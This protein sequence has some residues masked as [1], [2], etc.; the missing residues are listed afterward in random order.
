VALDQ[1]HIVR[2][3]AKNAHVLQEDAKLMED[4]AIRVHAF[5]VDVTHEQAA[6]LKANLLRLEKVLNSLECE[7]SRWSEPPAMSAMGR[8][9]HCAK[10]AMGGKQT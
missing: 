6:R 4:G 2:L 9:R 1:V 3:L 10:S 8:S 5:G 7:R